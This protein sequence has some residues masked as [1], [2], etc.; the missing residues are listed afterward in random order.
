MEF[1]ANLMDFN[2]EPGPWA[3]QREDEGW[4]AVGVSDHYYVRRGSRWY[5]HM[6]VAAAQLAAATQRMRITSAFANN[7]FRSPVEFVQASLTMQ[8]VSGGRWEAGLGAGWNEEELVATGQPFP[9]P[10]ERADRYIEA[11]RIIRELFDRRACH[12]D[13]EYY[14]VHIDGMAG[15]DDVASPP[16]VGAVGGPRTTRG[17]VPLLDRVDLKLSSVANRSGAMDYRILRRLTRRDLAELVAKVRAVDADVA[18]G[19]F[20][21][22]SADVDADGIGSADAESLY[23]SLFGPAE[24]IAETLLGLTEDGISQVNVCPKDEGTFEKLARYLF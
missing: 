11:V 18:L 9:S 20:A 15:F 6:W 12:F 21:L 4:S 10:R 3:K 1:I 16:L 24:K 2:V 5:P 14:Q 8:R 7:L 13:G 23:G 22:C 17:V 19:F